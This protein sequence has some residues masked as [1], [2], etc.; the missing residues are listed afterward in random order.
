[1][2]P[3]E[4]PGMDLNRTQRESLLAKI[5]ATVAE[6]YYDPSFDGAAWRRI[7]ERHRGSIVNTQSTAAF[8]EAVADMLRELSPKTLG[9]LSKRTP[10]NPRNAIN[11]SFSVQQVADGLRWVF[12]DV[13]PEGVAAQVGAKSG[14]VLLT[15]AGKE[16]WP[17]S[18]TA[19]EPPFEMSLEIPVKVRR[20]SSDL[21]FS[22]RTGDPK[23]KDNPYSDLKA[24]TA[25]TIE[26]GIAYLK[27]SLFQGKLGI[28]FANELDSL[29]RG[30]LAGANQ[31]IIDLR[32]NPGGGIGGLTLMSYLTPD[33]L[34]IGYSK[35]RKM[36]QDGTNPSSLPVFD[37]VPRSKLAVPGLAIKFMRKTSVF[38]YTEAQG[39]RAFRGRVAILVNEH[40]TGAAEMLAQFAKENSLVTIVGT[41]TPG[42]LVSR[43]ATKLG[44]GYRL[45]LPVAAYVSAKGTQIEGNG[46]TPD[47]AVPWSFTDAVAGKDNQLAAAIEQVLR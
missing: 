20:G 10:I 14:D 29:F 7:V 43:S 35:N 8:E 26:G 23:Y 31:L 33:R 16:M 36:A 19:G 17:G 32:G 11:A 47:V 46:I 9:L 15:A 13:L 40:T 37:R 4:R 38:L 25:S 3:Y 24:L 5:E 45:I 44:A 27:I 1:M 39:S 30:R 12:Q 41:K 18:E 34:P 6:K 2:A 21:S 28:D 42:R 22:L